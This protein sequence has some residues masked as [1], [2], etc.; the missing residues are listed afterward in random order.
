MPAATFNGVVVAESDE[1][2]M[3][4]GNHYFPR[5]SVQWD[6]FSESDARQTVCPW[7]G[8]ADYFDLAVAGESARGVAWTYHDPKSEAEQIRDYVAF[9][10]KVSVG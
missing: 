4:E 3:V 7:K 8:V 6:Y 5:D 9:Y 1:T 2:I 10:P